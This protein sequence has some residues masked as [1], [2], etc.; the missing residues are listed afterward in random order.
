MDEIFTTK[1][2]ESY[3]FQDN[4]DL[5]YLIEPYSFTKLTKDQS[6]IEINSLKGLY[7]KKNKTI[8]L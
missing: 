1:A 3:I 6:L 8:Y 7:D 5:I 2:K 4:P